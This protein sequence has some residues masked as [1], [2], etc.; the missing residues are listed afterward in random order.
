M[1]AY[2]IS[3]LEPY[4]ISIMEELYLHDGGALLAF[5]AL[6]YLHGGGATLEP[7]NISRMEAQC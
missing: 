6:K 7:Y 4:N 1:L 5:R 3:M 2:N